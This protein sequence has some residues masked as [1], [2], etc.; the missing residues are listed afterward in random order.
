MTAWTWIRIGAILGALAV[1]I[2]AF[3]AHGLRGKF[4]R[5]VAESLRT[6]AEADRLL[7]V[8]ET[9]VRYHIVHALALVAVGLVG[10]VSR[11]HG[12][13][14]DAAG[15]LFLA[16]V[17]LFSGSLYALT[18]SGVRWLGAVTPFGG[19]ALILGWLAL[20]WSARMPVP[21]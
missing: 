19:V 17:V 14:L 11:R 20:A 2:G 21:E 13:G 10:A 18:L 4:D 16:G 9:G 7:E 15:W 3:G 1:G 5:D 8:Y 12:G 6:R